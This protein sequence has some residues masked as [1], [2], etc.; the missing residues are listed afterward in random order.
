M[1]KYIHIT[2]KKQADLI[3]REDKS[4]VQLKMSQKQILNSDYNLI[5]IPDSA[6]NDFDNQELLLG[7]RV[8]RLSSWI[9][10]KWTS[11]IK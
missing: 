5:I 4:Q 11:R 9:I 3:F 2:T 8:L 7:K 10:M 6:S 1:L